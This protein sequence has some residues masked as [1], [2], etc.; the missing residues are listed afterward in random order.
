M[1]PEIFIVSAKR[2]AFGRF[3]GSLSALSPVA[4][5]VAAGREVLD[6]VDTKHIDLCILG[7]VLAA[8]HG[9]NIAR[10][11]ALALE[12]PQATPAFT[13]NQMCASGMTSVSQ[14]IQAIRAGEARVVL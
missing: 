10:Q 11:V 4:L 8:G 9:M 1:N 12:L 5:A 13:V 14:G 3:L 7:N 2:T 6:G